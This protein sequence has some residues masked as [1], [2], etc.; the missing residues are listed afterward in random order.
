[1]KIDSDFV[2][3]EKIKSQADYNLFVHNKQK[4]PIV[5]DKAPKLIV[6]R[7]DYQNNQLTMRN[8]VTSLIIDKYELKQ[9]NV[10]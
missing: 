5:K 2:S 6:F 10:T 4:H 9:Y 3:F 1:M 7:I 8:C